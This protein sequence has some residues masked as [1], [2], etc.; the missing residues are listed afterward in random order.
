MATQSGIT[1][2]IGNTVYYKMGEKYYMRSAPRKYKQTK[3]T[4]A[5]ATEFGKASSIGRIIREN[6]SNV[7]FNADDRKM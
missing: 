2:R 4:K 3:A 5:K 6:L 7:I 1:G